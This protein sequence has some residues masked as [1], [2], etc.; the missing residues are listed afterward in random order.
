MTESPRPRFSLRDILAHIRRRFPWPPTKP[1]VVTPDLRDLDA[2]RRRAQVGVIRRAFR[3][4]GDVAV[5]GPEGPRPAKDDA[6]ALFL[7]RPGAALVRDNTD[8][9]RY[10]DEFVDFFTRRSSLF[11]GREPIRSERRLPAGLVLVEMPSRADEADAVLTTLDEIDE[12]RREQGLEGA[13]AQPD[14][15]LYVTVRGHLCPA[16]EPERPRATTPVPALVTTSDV[17]RG[18]RVSVVDSGWWTGSATHHSTPWVSDVTADADDE[19]HLT[20]SVIHEY[21]GHGNFVAG[22]VK[23][24]APG[25]RVEVEGVL[26]Y[27]GA[28]F[29]SEI[30]E[31]LNDAL[32]END[33][34]QLISIS[35][36]THTRRNLG[37]LGLEILLAAKGADDGVRTIVVAAAGN[38]ESDE[39]FYPAA[40]D[41]VVGVGSVD[42]DQKR[43]DFSN[44]GKW[45]NVYA[46]GRDLVNA[47]PVGTYTCHYPENIHGGVPEVRKFDGLATWSGTSFA[48]PVVTGAIA[49][50]MSATGNLD[51]PRKA[52]DELFSSAPTGPGGEKII[53]PL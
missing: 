26:P 37:L 18:V 3:E 28:V 53:G 8:E 48:T 33:L 10:Y 40:Y 25:S 34:P 12:E 30:C 24:L 19:E 17:G 49:A 4:L 16:T 29:E 2:E 20:G 36:G 51:D 13:V 43:S 9:R 1:P 35:A 31:Q 44:Y 45:V 46:R 47:F 21:A 14:H 38:D 7:Y 42:P 22:V 41:W 23:C 32:D 6:E 5:A 27:G 15:V 52:Y 50:H 11:E 39:P